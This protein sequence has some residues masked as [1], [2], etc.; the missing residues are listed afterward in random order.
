MD[1][2]KKGGRTS[3]VSIPVILLISAL[4]GSLFL[5]PSALITSRPEG[6]K[7]KMTGTLGTQDVEARLWQDPFEALE[8][9]GVTSERKQ[10]V[11][12]VL[13]EAPKLTWK[14]TASV[15]AGHEIEQL[16]VR[17]TPTIWTGTRKRPAILSSR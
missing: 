11:D 9:A 12:V 5:G 13:S 15:D 2:E 7:R 17:L 14:A 8:L 1:E 4:A 16:A 10:D 3:T 6:A